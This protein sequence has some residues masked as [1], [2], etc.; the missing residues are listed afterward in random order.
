MELQGVQKLLK[1]DPVEPF[2]KKERYET[3]EI[4]DR[5]RNRNVDS[6]SSY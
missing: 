4:K 6:S 1:L 2:Y 3:L 5:K